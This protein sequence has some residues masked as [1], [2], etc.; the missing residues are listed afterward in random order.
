MRRLL[1]ARLLQSVIVVLLS[2]MSPDYIHNMWND[3]SGKLLLGGGF[4]MQMMGLF[5]IRKIV[6]I[7]V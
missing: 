7:E 1:A 5:V 3:F 2:F 6:D 4:V